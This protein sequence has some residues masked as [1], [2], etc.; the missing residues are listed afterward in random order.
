MENESKPVN[1]DKAPPQDIVAHKKLVVSL[2]IATLCLGVPL[3]VALLYMSTVG[4]G[5]ATMMVV[6]FSGALGAFVSALKRLFAFQSIFPDESVEKI[7]RHLDLYAVI[8]SLVPALVGT[9]G[10]AFVYVV[11]A[12]GLV[13]GPLFPEFSCQG[14][15]C[16]TFAGFLSSWSPAGPVDY[17]KAIVWGVVAGFSERFVPDIMNGLA[18]RAEMSK[19]G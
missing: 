3:F 10:A 16:N 6:M 2:A 15:D 12:G 19:E 4:K 9:L 18:S 1:S 7:F 11:F 13:E 5:P 8:Y 17:A 14:G